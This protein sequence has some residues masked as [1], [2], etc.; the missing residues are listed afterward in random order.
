MNDQEDYHRSHKGGPFSLAT[1]DS[2][3]KKD[4]H[5]YHELGAAESKVEVE[6]FCQMD[7]VSFFLDVLSYFG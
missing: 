6:V 7:E 1:L 3:E 4:Y 2:I 5:G